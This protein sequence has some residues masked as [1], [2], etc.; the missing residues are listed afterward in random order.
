MPGWA[1]TSVPARDNDSEDQR[2]PRRRWGRHWLRGLEPEDRARLTAVQVAATRPAFTAVLLGGAA[3]LA[4]TAVFQWVG[5]AP[6]IGYPWWVVLLS[7]LAVGVMAWG[8][9]RLRDWRLRLVLMLA[10]TATIG[11]FLSVPL[12]DGAGAAAQFPIR[13]GLFHLIP[14]ALL[15]LTVRKLSVFLLVATVVALAVVRLVLYGVPPSGAAIYW[16]YTATTVAFGL[17]LSSYRTD[18]AVEAFRARQILWKQAATDA[19]TGLPNR[20]GWERDATRVY[21][22]AGHRGAPRSLVFFDV[23]KF[24]D[25]NDRWGHAVGDEVLRSL[26]SALAARLGPDC[27][28]ARMGGEEFIALQIDAVPAAVERFA[29]RV[30]ADFARLNAR[31]GCTISA[32]IAFALPG[33]PLADCLRR[34]DEALYAAKESGRDRIVIAP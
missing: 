17:M 29:Q 28:A 5:L 11:V 3:M 27:Y 33:E 18:F 13:T 19:L 8:N 32:G 22:D 15:A 6:G 1:R 25:V 7:A 9:W 31:H 21:D 23:D 20:T 16:L 2:S 12:P 24:K 14:I 10:A 34:A 4:I 30:R 26:G